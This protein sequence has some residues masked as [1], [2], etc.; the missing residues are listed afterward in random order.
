MTDMFAQLSPGKRVTQTPTCVA[1]TFSCVLAIP[2]LSVAAA[3]PATSQSTVETDTALE[4]VVV[5]ATRRTEDLNQVA[6][7]V[8][9]FS[10][11]TLDVRGIRTAEDLVGMAPGVDLTQLG[12]LQANISIRGISN[13]AGQTTTG[14]A[15]TGIYIDDT[16]V[17]IRS[18]GL[19]P[20]NPLP[21]I[22]D[23]DR[24]EVLRGPQGTL[25]GSGSEGGAIRFISTQPSVQDWSGNSRAELASTYHGG[26]SYEAG[27]AIGGPMI[28][29]V[30][31][32]RVSAHLRRDGGDVDRI[33]YPT[34]AGPD[35]AES[36]AN[37]ADTTSARGALLWVPADGLKITPSVYVRE[38]R[39]HDTSLYWL[40]LSNP[41]S[42]RYVSGNGEASPDINRSDLT[43]LKIDWTYGPIELISNTSYYD[44]RENN[45]SDFR[46]LITNTLEPI[47]QAFIAA[48]VPGAVPIDPATV[49]ATP[50]YYDNGTVRNT[51][52]NWTQE[53][54]LQSTDPAARLSWLTGLFFAD[55]RQFNDE[56]NR[57]PFIALESGSPA[58]YNLAFAGVPLVNGQYL[59][60]EQI[61]TLDKQL[62]AFGELNFDLTQHLRLTAGLRVAR[63]ETHFNDVADG[64]LVGGPQGG[65]SRHVETPKTPKY[66]IT[67]RFDPKNLVYASVANGFRIGGGNR[68]VS[69]T[70]CAPD[71]QA[72]GLPSAPKTYNSDRVRSYELG[73]KSEPSQRF[74]IAASTYYVEWFNIIQP[75][76]LVSCGQTITTNLGKAVSKGAD[77]E[78]TFLPV[79]GLTFD[80]MVNYDD[81]KYTQS[82]RLP[83]AT[84]NIVTDGWTLGQAPWTVNTS[85]QYKFRGLREWASYVRGDVDFRNSNSGLT[86]VTDPQS[87]TYNPYLRA[88]PSTLD[89]RLR[90]G[91]Q[92][93][94]WD[95]SLFVDNATN[96]H[97]VLN[98]QSDS[99]GG[100]TL[101]AYP[102]VR[103]VTVGLT[104]QSRF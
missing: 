41:S 25:F 90:Y 45:L 34:G 49:F 85:L 32:F 24:V 17:Q 12:N 70:L 31:G 54:R 88:N 63:T 28:D 52:N 103:P 80:I 61:R 29:G 50:G 27:A 60:T 69:P 39:T 71:L 33:P 93:S 98:R 59:Y 14:D 36:S 62:A 104:V 40:G 10:A 1:V 101:Y 51:Q 75:V 91:V 21:D 74:R 67:Y 64:P 65:S 8:A 81:A 4:E 47:A 79:A 6:E 72:L 35:P 92:V 43:T 11:A 44:R 97:P 30:L 23:V 58:T 55:N 78:V 57:T 77:L 99:P 84:S 66:A 18:I 13:T 96:N 2:F 87:A 73:A 76:D 22:F 95:V 16:P 15:T 89:V 53:I 56:N 38:T 19:A 83:D 20:G 7:S 3:G 42:Q 94:D 82:I 68:D 86:A 9:V 26:T 37:Y 46:A 5:T 102:P 100:L 48:G